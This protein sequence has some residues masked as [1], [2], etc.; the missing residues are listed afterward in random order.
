M[1]TK[2]IQ[3]K[4]RRVCSSC[5]Y[6]HFIE[7]KV[8]V[9]VLVVEDDALLL[10]R[11]MMEPEKG[12]WSLP[13]GYLDH[14]DDPVETAVREAREETNLQVEV[15]GLMDVYQ[16]PVHQGGASV[17]ILYRA[18]RLGGELR[19]GDDADRAA[20]FALDDLPELGFVSTRD[21]V[22]RLQDEG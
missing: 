19:A 3:G 1:A 4:P 5:G 8:G 7:P 18:R 2:P 11:R 15:T 12:K 9:G 6:I 10:V 13:A 16:N 21:A 17:F 20:F 22:R 14:G